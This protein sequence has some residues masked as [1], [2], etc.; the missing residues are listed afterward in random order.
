MNRR[1]I[2]AAA[3][4]ALALFAFLPCQA[5]AKPINVRQRVEAQ[6]LDDLHAHI[7]HVV[8]IIQENRSFDNFFKDFPGADTVDTGMSHSGPVRL[9]PVNLDTPV[10]VDHQHKGFLIE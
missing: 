7:K 4:A 8:I 5:G 9:H 6:Y 3:A 2:V 1:S 10:D